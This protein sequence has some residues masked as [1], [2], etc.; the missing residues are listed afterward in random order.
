[1]KLNVAGIIPVV[2]LAVTMAGACFAQAYPSKPIRLIVPSGPGS[3]PDIRGRWLAEKLHATLGQS[4]IVDNKPGGASIIGTMAAIQSPADGY[5]LLMSHQGVM[6]LN[7][8]LY[9][10]LPYNPLK[11]LAPVSRLVVSPMMLAVHPDV[12]A[13]SVSDLI[14]LAREKPGQLNFGSP[15]VGTPPHMAAALFS[16]LAHIDVMH[17]PYKTAPAAQVDLMGGRLTFTFDGVVSQLPHVRAGALRA[18]AVTSTKRLPTLPDVPTVAESGLP[19]YEYLAWMGICAPA[20]TP[21]DIIR[22]LNTEISKILRTQE[23]RDWLAAQGGEI[24]IETPEEFATFI[25]AE[26]VRWGKL[27]REAGI[28]AD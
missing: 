21:N 23:A 22:R 5:T 18:L 10:D 26:H 17:I 4:I 6:A 15:G 9:P 24:V 28:K 7:P 25:R 11:D 1:M 20:A 12:P 8:H 3:P 19:G 27:I 14:K 16:R 2:L 13:H